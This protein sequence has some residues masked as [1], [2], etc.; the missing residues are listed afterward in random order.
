LKKMIICLTLALMLASLS[1]AGAQFMPLRSSVENYWNVMGS[2]QLE[3]SVIGTNE[4]ERGD[5][6]I[7]YV[8]LTNVGQ[9]TGYEPDERPEDQKEKTLAEREFTL[10]KAKTAAFPITAMLRSPTQ[11][12]E[13]QSGPQIV[14]GL[15][16]G[17]KSRDPMEF[18]IEIDN[19]A[20]EGNYTL[21]LDLYYLWQEN[22]GVGAQDHETILGLIGFRQ[23]SLF[24]MKMQSINL[25]V[26][27]KGK[28]D[29][30]VVNVDAELNAGQS[31]GI[32][33]ITYKNVGKETAK[34]AI[35]R[36]SL[37]M[38]FSSDDDQAFLG[39]LSPQDEATVTFKIDVKEGAAV[40]N[41]SINS[42][43][44]YTDLKGNSITSETVSIPL[45]VGPAKKSYTRI[46][47]LA[48]IALAAIGIYIFK[49]KKIK[50]PG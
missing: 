41:Y 21:A 18:A 34:D 2:P 23:S 26:V 49:K 8:G 5:K 9:I 48:L 31:G 6:A 36:V 25:S 19:D 4:F 10:E 13:I 44:K 30:E 1:P 17:A 45:K 43:V 38:P 7:L 20:P 35:A 12:I 28:A 16:S 24:A 42:E 32:T 40:G 37:F 47:A 50:L 33:K 15:A 27:V 11:Y 14:E 29:F 39:T 3:A 46:A 22:T